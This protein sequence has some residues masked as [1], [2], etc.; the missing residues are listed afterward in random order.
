MARIARFSERRLPLRAS[1]WH[2][3]VLLGDFYCKAAAESGESEL[4]EDIHGK[5]LL[6]HSWCLLLFC[7]GHV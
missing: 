7:C 5:H 2:L 3:F 1:S 6:S 4:L